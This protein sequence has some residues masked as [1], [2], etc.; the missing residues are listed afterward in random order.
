M[1]NAIWNGVI[2]FGLLNIPVALHSGERSTDLHFRML[3]SRDN[4]PIRFERVNA[5]TGEEVPWKQIVKA[6]EYEK[7]NY[8]VLE[9]EDFKAAAPDSL[10]TVEVTSFVDRES[11]RPMYY[12]KPYYLVPGKKAEKGYVLLREVLRK[13]N[14]VAMGK[15]VIR[16]REYLCGLLPIEN[17]LVMM[18]LRFPQEIVPADSFK[19][20]GG[21]LS[22]YRI[23]TKEV[24]MAEELVQSMSI[25]FE[26]TA[27][28]DDFRT[29][30]QEVIDT[31]IRSQE[32]TVTTA[33]GED[34]DAEQPSTNV[35]DFMALL[36]KSLKGKGSDK[37]ENDAKKTSKT[38][39][40]TQSKTS[41]ISRAG[42]KDAS[43]SES[44]SGSKTASKIGSKAGSKAGSKTR[45]KLG[46][47][48][49]GRTAAGNG[50]KSGHGSKAVKASKTARSGSKTARRTGSKTASKAARKRAA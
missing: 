50:S 28:V 15:V 23:S 34:E 16:T 18:L 12:E 17:A 32:G 25:D 47:K 29:R 24:A 40:K 42:A 20:P 7:G 43:K 30:L 27:Y 41:S 48:G 2:S 10:E 9:Q 21:G 45:F 22:E 31:R 19:L 37:V 4:S 11:I 33:D 49:G 46:S 8:V 3:D 36:R 13:T 26:P 44:G 1:A 38:Q 6:F 14:R 5:E 39:P 35:V